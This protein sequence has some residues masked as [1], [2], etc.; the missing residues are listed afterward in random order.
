MEEYGPVED[1]E[2]EENYIVTFKDESVP[3]LASRMFMIH[4]IR[5]RTSLLGTSRFLFVRDGEENKRWLA[6]REVR[7]IADDDVECDRAY[8]FVDYRT[9]KGIFRRIRGKTD[10]KNVDVMVTELGEDERTKLTVYKV[11]VDAL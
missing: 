2:L 9:L 5:T 8:K 6:E 10:K 3:A 7:R 4:D 1:L 11:P